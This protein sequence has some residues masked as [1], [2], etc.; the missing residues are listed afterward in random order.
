MKKAR[1]IV[2]IIVTLC[3]LLTLVPEGAFAAP[4]DT[5]VPFDDVQTTDWFY[6]TVQ[7]VYDEGLMAG[8]GDRI[9][10]P[11]Q[12]TTRGMIVTI[13]HRMAGSPEA[14]AQDFTDVDPDAWYAPAINWS[15]ESG[16]GAGY[17]GGLFGPDDAITREQMASFLYR[18]AKLEGYDV[19]AVGDLNDFAD[20][21]AVSNWA[22]DVMSWAVGAGLFAGRDNNQLAPQGLTTRAE[23]ATILMRYCENIVEEEVDEP[24]EP[25]K[26]EMFTVTF[27]YNYDNK[28]AY[29]TQ[30]VEDGKTA[31]EPTDPSRDGFNF[32]GWYT[33][34]SGK[35]A[36]K[37]TTKVT[38]DIT[39]YAKWKEKPVD[40]DEAYQ[41][42]M[43]KDIYDFDADRVL[44]VD[45]SDTEDNFL[46]VTEDVDLV[47]SSSATN[48]VT[49][50][51]ESTGKYV[52]SNISEEVRNLQAG[53]KLVLVSSEEKS[54]I[55]LKID[56]IS[57]S[58]NTATIT[59]NGGSLED[60]YEYIQIDQTVPITAS[61]I[62]PVDQGLHVEVADTKPPSTVVVGSSSNARS[63]IPEQAVILKA[64]LKNGQDSINGEFKLT[65]NVDANLNWD[66]E[67]FGKDFIECNVIVSSTFA[68]TLS[69]Q[70]AGAGKDW[71]IPIGK[72]SV[73]LGSTGL[74][75]NGEIGAVVK[76]SGEVTASFNST[77]NRNIGFTYSTADGYHEI[78]ETSAPTIDPKI[79]AEATVGAGLS[80]GLSL[81][82]A[83]IVDAGVDGSAGIEGKVKTDLTGVDK[84]HLCYLCLDGELYTF[85]K[86]GFKI[87]VGYSEAQWI[88]LNLPIVDAEKSLGKCYFSILSQNG[89]CQFGWGECPNKNKNIADIENLVII[90]GQVKSS[91][92]GTG[93]SDVSV[94]ST[95]GA[96]GETYETATASDGSFELHALGNPNDYTSLQFRKNNYIDYDLT[97]N[98]NG[99]K[100]HDVGTIEMT[101]TSSGEL[102]IPGD[103]SNLG[104]TAEDL[105]NPDDQVIVSEPF[106]AGDGS[107]DNPYQISSVANLLYLAEQV[108]NRDMYTRNKFFVLTK[109]LDLSQIESWTPIGNYEKFSGKFDGNDHSIDNMTIVTNYSDDALPPKVGLF[110]Y[111]R[112]GAISNLT[113]NNINIIQQTGNIQN[114]GGVA[115]M[116]YG[117]SIT[118]CKVTGNITISP[119]PAYYAGYGGITGYLI[120]EEFHP[121][122]KIVDCINYANINC[123]QGKYV[124]GIVGRAETRGDRDYSPVEIL[125]CKNYGSIIG[126]EYS[127]EIV[128]G[129]QQHND[130]VEIIVK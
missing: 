80:A 56:G 96:S 48:K 99:E 112:Y 116:A 93:V 64:N 39:L 77:I 10:S 70:L 17:G 49:S 27:D 115:G 87:T 19:S 111:V 127:G 79:E 69:L 32:D 62:E 119:Y 71:E 109:D 82:L 55:A 128:G 120:G 85:G 23:A 126:G 40:Y 121:Q 41:E 47:K 86:I 114:V 105:E 113:L 45:E 75:V 94:S 57:V 61:A 130:S 13:L 118:N 14:E 67:L 51:N 11:Q 53:D 21:S 50:A 46:V 25:E 52:I 29:T 110:G 102:I 20:A 59:S 58:G 1:K 92:S 24:D 2:S 122:A 107:E 26:A 100:L 76:K 30:K 123:G 18:Y 74:F 38:K 78:N 106:A 95:S 125:N 129:I 103:P 9:F 72:V 36:F 73:P 42:F 16:V 37:F 91:N 97:I 28:G 98:M 22:E 63:L 124:G 88:P 7:Y 89:A 65:M 60:F 66:P 117:T 8:T 104:D 33:D 90:T 83:Q 6:D 5:E 12:T 54:N 35:N 34:T 108:N 3:F 31:K 43:D 101:P 68:E 81:S 15:I 84:Q 44:Q 4:K